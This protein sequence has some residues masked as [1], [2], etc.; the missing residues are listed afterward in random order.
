M[1]NII[2]GSLGWR[3]FAA[4]GDSVLVG[5]VL[6]EGCPLRGL[7][8]QLT[9]IDCIGTF[10]YSAYWI[11]ILSDSAVETTGVVLNLALLCQ[12]QLLLSQ[13]LLDLSVEVVG[14][15]GESPLCGIAPPACLAMAL[16]NAKRVEVGEMLIVLSWKWK[17]C[18]NDL[19]RLCLVRTRLVFGKGIEAFA[20]KDRR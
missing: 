18:V 3:K 5:H 7:E 9:G 2:A 16:Y 10:L 12:I 17:M 15:V 1:E 6:L 19:E 20:L 11:F 14:T 4:C 13:L 8:D